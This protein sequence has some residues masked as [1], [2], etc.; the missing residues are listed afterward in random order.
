MERGKT[1]VFG[2]YSQEGIE[3]DN[4]DLPGIL[5]SGSVEYYD[6]ED[7]DYTQE[8]IF[9]DNSINFNSLDN[10]EDYVIN[11]NLS[12][13]MAPLMYLDLDNYLWDL[14]IEFDDSLDATYLDDDASINIAGKEYFF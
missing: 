8:L 4:E 10:E 7:E 13:R 3:F 1:I 5:S 14:K 6:G 9:G 12:N 11:A 2:Y